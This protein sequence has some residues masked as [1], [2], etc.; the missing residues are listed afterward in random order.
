AAVLLTGTLLVPPL[1]LT[2]TP[3]GL[4]APGGVVPVAPMIEVAGV[5]P[6]DTGGELLLTT[7]VG[8]TPILAAQWAAG[9]LDP[10]VAIVPPERVVPEHISPQELMAE[11]ARLLAESQAVATVV[12]LRMAGYEASITGSGVQVLRVLPESPSRGL[13]RP[14][15]RI[16]ALNAVAVRTAPDLLVALSEHDAAAPATVTLARDGQ[17][18]E[19]RLPLLPPAEPGGPPRIGIT[20]ATADLAADTPIPVRITPRS[21]AGGPSAGLMFTLAIYDR[22]TPGDLTRGWRVAGTGTVARDG[23][24]G[25]IGGVAQKVAAAERAGADY[26]LVP[27]ENAVDARWA[28]R[29][30][31]ILAVT[32]VAD[33]IEHLQRLPVRAGDARRSGAGPRG[34]DGH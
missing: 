21:I 4:Y 3:A 28:A 11:N 24:V 5:E 19:L 33:A 16:V 6:P 17:R 15:D 22:L 29:R 25:P 26:F 12:A 14:G 18:V 13:L 8:Q 1:A 32:H 27:Q 7:V 10:A 30:I 34:A 9:Q 20:V 23:R 2:P 31:T